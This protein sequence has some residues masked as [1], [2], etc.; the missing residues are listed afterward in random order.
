ML[1]TL[2]SHKSLYEVIWL[3]GQRGREIM[4]YAV[5]RSP[6]EILRR[7]NLKVP[8]T[9]EVELEHI[10]AQMASNSLRPFLAQT[11]NHHGGF[12]VTTGTPGS[13]ATLM[14]SGPQHRVA[15]VVRILR[16]ADKPAAQE[17]RQGQ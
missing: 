7:P 12:M 5:H 10:N 9:T 13:N 4:N 15:A 11:S 16:K 6:E 14:L 8:V 1:V 2:D 17:M 3:Q